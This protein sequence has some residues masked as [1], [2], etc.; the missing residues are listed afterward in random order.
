MAVERW[1]CFKWQHPRDDVSIHSV[2]VVNDADG[3]N[4]QR[5]PDLPLHSHC[6]P[7]GL[8]RDGG[9]VT[10]RVSVGDLVRA[11]S[12]AVHVGNGVLVDV[13]EPGSLTLFATGCI[14]LLLLVWL[15]RQGPSK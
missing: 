2:T 1:H 8:D 9:L 4:P 6:A 14:V 7:L 13:P 12:N 5:D 3:A 15:R 11:P 10:A